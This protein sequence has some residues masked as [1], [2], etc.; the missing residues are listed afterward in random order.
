WLCARLNI[1]NGAG[2]SKA[3][4]P[5]SEQYG[6]V[7]AQFTDIEGEGPVA[8]LTHRTG[9]IGDSRLRIGQGGGQCADLHPPPLSAAET[10]TGETRV[11]IPCPPLAHQ[12]APGL[13]ETQSRG[14]G[15]SRAVRHEWRPQAN[16]R[17]LQPYVTQLDR[18]P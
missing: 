13:H 16:P 9:K 8:R 7:G 2:F 11:E 3:N 18:P 4:G 17:V 12:H 6:G 1:Q 15:G 5:R 14:L 10:Q